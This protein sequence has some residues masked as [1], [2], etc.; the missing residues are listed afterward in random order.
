[1][2]P[3]GAENKEA[4][5]P[6]GEEFNPRKV[7]EDLMSG[8]EAQKLTGLSDEQIEEVTKQVR[9]KL[10]QQASLAKH[11]E[12]M[13]KEKEARSR[14]K[15]L[16]DDGMEGVLTEAGRGTPEL[17]FFDFLVNGRKFSCSDKDKELLEEFIADLPDE[18]DVTFLHTADIKIE[19]VRK[20]RKTQIVPKQES[21][22]SDTI[23]YNCT[24]R[25]PKSYAM[26]AY[27]DKRMRA[28]QIAKIYADIA[29]RQ[30]KEEQ[31]SETKAAGDVGT[32]A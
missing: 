5:P 12:Q 6:L 25:V 18:I 17:S 23:W 4:T 27:E 29:Y 32:A 28:E 11:Q 7:A 21:G 15:V 24:V 8:A 16:F 13:Q 30:W 31:E 3:T 14:G 1:M 2:K 20:G 22:K 26:L 19:T 10:R 9:R